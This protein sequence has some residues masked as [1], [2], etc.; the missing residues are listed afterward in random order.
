[1]LRSILIGAI[2]V[3][4]CANLAW[5]QDAPAAT[6]GAVNAYGYTYDDV[7][8][9]Q[10]IVLFW[11]AQGYT[12]CYGCPPQ[13]FAEMTAK[14]LPLRKFTSPHNGDVID[15]DDGSLDYDGDMIYVPGPCWDFEVHVQTTAGVVKLPGAVTG[16]SN[17]GVQ[18][19]PCCCLW[20][21]PGTVCVYVDKYKCWDICGNDSCA[22]QIVEWMMWK[23]FETHEALYGG[24]PVDELAFYASGLAPVDKNYKE[25]VPYM[26]IEYI[27]KEKNCCCYV[28][29]AYV[30]CCQPCVPCSPCVKPCDPCNPCETKCNSCAKPCVSKCNP[31]K[32]KCDPCNPCKTKCNSCAKPCAS[33]C[34]P[35]KPKCS[36]DMCTERKPKCSPCESK[37]SPCDIK[38]KP[39]CSPCKSKCNQCKP[40]CS[41]C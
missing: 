18:F 33:K 21:C 26:D 38:C 36:F 13:T 6:N 12:N 41:T 8:V 17:I 28:K 20:F 23:S 9:N 29:K 14:G 30:T 5:A 24:R 22:C 32:P 2:I 16:H 19:D 7:A 1:M 37:C 27:Y 40:A 34:N 4:C 10:G 3:V 39:K 35:C 31:C 25:Y 15:P 11:Y